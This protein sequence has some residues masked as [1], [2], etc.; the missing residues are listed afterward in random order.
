MKLF[1]LLASTLLP[2]VATAQAWVPGFGEPAMWAGAMTTW[3]ADGPGPLPPQLT[4]STGQHTYTDGLGL[5]SNIVR[6]DG[7]AWRTVNLGNYLSG[8]S[9]HALAFWNG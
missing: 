7:R 6:F 2:C 8:F 4:H 9:P 3:D 5:S 1:C